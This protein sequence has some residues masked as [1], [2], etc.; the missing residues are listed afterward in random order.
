MPL[1]PL[2]LLQMFPRHV[3][4]FL[5]MTSGARALPM[6]M[7]KPSLTSL[8]SQS[9]NV[10]ILFT[11][12]IGFT[13]MS[14]QVQPAQVRP[15][16]VPG[17]VKVPPFPFK[18]PGLLPDPSHTQLCN[19]IPPTPTWLASTKDC[20]DLTVMHGFALQ[21]MC[22]L[23]HLFTLLDDL[24]DSYEVFKVETA[25]DCYMQVQARVASVQRVPDA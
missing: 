9:D 10:T 8:A 21:V 13:D 12:V 6:G 25:G 1:L 15:S 17:R 4:E 7:P 5:A 18:P 20:I 22:Y 3:L 11:D 2:L 16:P 14:K 19:N 24:I 23:N